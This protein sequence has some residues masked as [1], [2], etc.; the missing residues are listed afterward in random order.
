MIRQEDGA[1]P[2]TILIRLMVGGIFFAEGLQK[3]LYAEEVGAGRF[4]KI[5]LPA[6][7]IL[8]VLVGSIE[9]ACGFLVLLGLF[10][11]VAVVPLFGVIAV[12]FVTTKVPIFLGREFLGFSLK[13]LPYYGF[14]GMFHEARTDLSMICGLLFLSLVGAG[15]ISFDAQRER[16]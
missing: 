14:F 16:R 8:A 12:A 1:P 2:A 5:G 7:E 3:F 13:Q 4:A 10:T 15:S 11:R 6:P 9:M